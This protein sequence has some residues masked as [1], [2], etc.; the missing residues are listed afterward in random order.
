MFKIERDNRILKKR[1]YGV[2]KI[3]NLLCL[4]QKAKR[5]EADCMHCEFGEL[6]GLA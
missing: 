4:Q 6:Q 5:K 3:N 2:Q 1:E